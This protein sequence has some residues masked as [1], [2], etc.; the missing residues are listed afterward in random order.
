MRWLGERVWAASHR[1]VLATSYDWCGKV[2]T[3]NDTGAARDQQD[4]CEQALET[5]RLELRLR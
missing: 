4:T 1:G 5:L 2:A 3:G